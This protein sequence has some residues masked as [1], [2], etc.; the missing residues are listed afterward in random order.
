MKNLAN[1]KI[2]VRTREYLIQAIFQML[3]DILTL[4]IVAHIKFLL[5][6]GVFLP[7]ITTCIRNQLICL[8][9]SKEYTGRSFCLRDF[10][11]QD[12]Q[13]FSSRTLLILFSYT[14]LHTY[15]YHNPTNLP[16]SSL[17]FLH[18]TLYTTY[19]CIHYV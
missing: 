12:M 16:P 19:V 15:T 14:I 10:F 13:L 3:F 8:H 6:W 5:S 11:I 17:L 18:D 4:P 2:A 1:F 9:H 7:H